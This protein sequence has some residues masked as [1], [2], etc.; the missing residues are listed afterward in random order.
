MSLS[1][2]IFSFLVL[3]SSCFGNA[4][5]RPSH[6][7]QKENTNW[8]ITDLLKSGELI[9]E[10][11]GNPKL[12]ESPYGKAVWFDGE[13]DG[14][15]LDELPLKGLTE[16][17]VEMIFCP[18]STQ[19][20]FEQRMLHIGEDRGDRMLLELRAVNGNWYFDGYAKSGENKKALIDEQLTHPLGQWYHVAFVVTPNSMTTFVNGTQELTEDFP[21]LPIQS[22]ATS[23]GTR[24]DKRSWFKG[25]IYKIKITPQAIKPIDFM[26]F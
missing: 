4:S 17:T 7:N 11:T 13:D 1:T 2:T 20:P 18:D 3:F 23:I 9:A 25:A 10:T 5:N 21:F 22:G 15:W 24:I 12:T 14:L 26:A 19:A 8:I 6:N 16:F